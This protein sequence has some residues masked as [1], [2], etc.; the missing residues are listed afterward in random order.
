V[1]FQ[2]S[3]PIFSGLSSIYQRGVLASQEKQLVYGQDTLLDTLSY[4]QV[5]AER[6]LDTA[7]VVL[8]GSKDA[9][10]LSKAS[11]KEAQRDYKLQTINY[12]QLLTSQQNFL[13]AESSFIQAKYSYISAVAVTSRHQAFQSPM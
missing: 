5:T 1:G 10:D 2:L 6:N 4:N 11:L 7:T 8:R 9:D 12:L 3:I 13:A